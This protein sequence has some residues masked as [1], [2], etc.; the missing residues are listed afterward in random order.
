MNMEKHVFAVLLLVCLLLSDSDAVSSQ[1]CWIVKTQGT[2][3]AGLH[4]VP[5]TSA[6]LTDGFG[7]ERHKQASTVTLPKLWDVL[8]DPEAGSISVKP[9]NFDRTRVLS[10]L[11][12][13]SNKNW[14]LLD[15]SGFGYVTS[16]PPGQYADYS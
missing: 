13:I 8:A 15:E 3:H 4:G 1:D 5:L 7:A 10:L 2:L 12:N 16:L 14:R 11:A 9:F 6:R